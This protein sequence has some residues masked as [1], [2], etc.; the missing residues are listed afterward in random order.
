MTF[1][2]FKELLDLVSF[3]RPND[4]DLDELRELVHQKLKS[5]CEHELYTQYKLSESDEDKKKFL[6]RYTNSKFGTDDDSCL[7]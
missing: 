4:P 7:Q 5:L 1:T 6:E 3:D 2:Q